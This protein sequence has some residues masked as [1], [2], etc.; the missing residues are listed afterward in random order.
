MPTAA[1]GDKAAAVAAFNGKR[2][3][4]FG[5]NNSRF[6]QGCTDYE[7]WK[8][9]AQEYGVTY[10]NRCAAGCRTLAEI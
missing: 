4:R 8:T 2:I 9:V 3:V 5:A 1:A 10:C 7:R 6:P